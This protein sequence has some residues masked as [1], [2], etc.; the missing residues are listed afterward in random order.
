GGQHKEDTDHGDILEVNKL[1]EDCCRLMQ[2]QAC[3]DGSESLP[4]YDGSCAGKRMLVLL[5]SGA[6][7]SYISPNMVKNLETVQVEA[8]EVETAGGHRL[9][10]DKMVNVDFNLDGCNMTIKAYILD[11]KFDFVLGRNWLQKYTPDVDWSTDNWTI[12]VN[13]ET[14][15]LKPVRYLGESGLRYLLSHKQINRAIRHKEVKEVYL[16]HFSDSDLEENKIPEELQPLV[17]EYQDIF[18]DE[19]PG[20]PPDRGFEHVIDTGDEKPVSRPPYKMSPLELDELRRQLNELL[21]LGLVVPSASPWGSPV[22]FVKKADGTMRMCV[23]YRA[24]N[25]KTIRI[26]APLPRIDECLERLQGA[27]YFTSLDL[28]SGYHQIKIRESDIPKTAFNTRYGQYSWKVLPFG[29]CNAPPS[30]Q[31]LMNKV[32]GDLLDRCCIV[33][34]DDI[35][36]FSD[37]WDKHKEH[38]KMVLDKLR[39]N[40][41][42]ANYKKCE[43]GKEEITFLGFR[44]S[45]AGIL[46]ASDKVKAI[47]EWKPLNNVQE[48]R[49]FIGL[50]QHFRRFIPNFASM[51]A[52]LTDLTR[53]T[54]PKKRKIQ[55]TE[56]CQRSFDLIKEK[57]IQ[58]PVLQAPDPKRPYRVEVDASDVGVGAVLLQEGDDKQWHPL[59]YESRK[60]S[61]AERNYPTQ[62][63]ELL[64]ILHALRTWRCFL[65]GSQY[66]VRSDHHPLKY[67]RSQSKYTPRLVRWMNELELYDPTVISYQ[68]GKTM[69]VPDALSR[70][71][72]SGAPG[73]DTME[74]QFL[75]AVSPQSIP[76]EHR[77]DWPSYYVDR[78]FDLPETVVNFLDQEK[79]HFV[80]KDKKVYRLIKLK[81]EDGTEEIK[82][83][84][85]LP[86]VQRA[87][88][89]NSFH[90]A[91]GHSGSATLFDLLRFRVWWPSMKADIKEWLQRCPSCQ[92][93][94]RRSRAHHDVMHPLPVPGAFERWHLDFIGELPKSTKGNRWILVAV[95][96]A[97]NYPIARAVPVASSKA[98]ADFLYEEIVMRFSCPKEIVT[99]RGANFMSKVVRFYTE[100][101]K[102]AH[103]FTSAFHA[104]S[105]SKCERYNGVLKQMLRKYTNGALHI[106]DQYL[107]AALFACRIRTHTTAKYSPYYLTYGRDPVLPGDFLRPYIPDHALQDPRVIA[108]LTA[109]ELENLDQARAAAKTRMEA[110][111]QYDKDRWDKALNIR[112]FDIGDYVKMTHEGRYGLE[113]VYKGPY[114]IVDKN[115][116]FGT[117]Q[118]ETIQGKLLD[119]WVHVDRL[120]K[121]N[122]D[123]EP[124]TPWFDPTA[125]RRAWREAMRLP[126]EDGVVDKAKAPSVEPNPV[127]PPLVKSVH[128][129][130]DDV[131]GRTSSKGGGVVASEA[132]FVP[133]SA[134]AP[135][136]TSKRR[137]QPRNPGR[138]RVN[139]ST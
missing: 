117:Y 115:S 104:R 11:T 75:Y 101:I 120:A 116:D 91:F 79:E 3:K 134:S 56:E 108:E 113:P 136:V 6:S 42:Y 54:G 22:L 137:F 53:G 129:H 89:V 106:W 83:V 5:D 47:Q 68:P 55:W 65:E 26:N 59:A 128:S 122:F 32:L 64:A 66:E 126:D 133:S 46:P 13:G 88:K 45:A 7:S 80:V 138:R 112:D 58:A 10:I 12:A 29:L 15:I 27:K 130:S 48:V 39:D 31:A 38:V 124:T 92:V 123:T 82:E 72:Y 71:D 70:H 132:G 67:L 51:A 99:D 139:T 37:S 2:L 20:L 50:A 74:P 9:R 8:R 73:K 103:R 30:F 81:H 131:R 62:E 23:D 21:E 49:Q 94:S 85:F 102:I 25:K 100:R 96:Y 52:P 110:I 119:S 95:D 44:V 76:P 41:L 93:N 127:V 77:N 4:L 69:H 118:L 109:Q 107:D 36:I 90:E 98:V 111:G 97:T 84:R 35:L 125:S 40:E 34:L 33:Y 14:K 78:P 18:R 60:L 135:N 105:N 24:T 17:E 86:F 61:S 63:R 57:L 16:L 121:V 19:L 28:K 43:F 87:D 1:Q 114:V